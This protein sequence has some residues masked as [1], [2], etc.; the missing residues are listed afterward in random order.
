MSSF[1]SDLL[2]WFDLLLSWLGRVSPIKINVLQTLLYSM[3][4]FP[5]RIN[6]TVFSDI[7]KAVSKFIWHAKK[8]CLNHKTLWLSREK[9]GLSMPDFMCYNWACHMRIVLGWHKHFLDSWQETYIDAWHCHLCL[10]SALLLMRHICFQR[11]SKTVWVEYQNQNLEEDCEVH[12]KK[13]YI[14]SPAT[15]YTEQSLSPRTG[16]E[17]VSMLVWSWYQDCRWFVQIR[18]KYGVPSQHIYGHLRVRHFIN[19]LDLFKNPA[20]R[21]NYWLILVTVSL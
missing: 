1:K 16:Y 9:G 21:L 13:G 15:H 18:A 14:S 20:N 12:P 17:H 3:Q 2:R 11:R 19:S 5:L 7:D 6:K 4:M 10:F 8:K